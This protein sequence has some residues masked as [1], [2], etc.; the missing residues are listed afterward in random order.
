MSNKILITGA[1]G[2]IGFYLA[3]KL[4]KDNFS[5]YGID[6]LNDYYDVALKKDRL[7]I[8]SSQP[9][10]AFERIDLSDRDSLFAFIEKVKPSIVIN[11]AAQ[12]GV[13][14]SI[15][16]P[17]AYVESNLVGFAN[18]LEAC[19]TYPVKHL[20]YASSSSVYGANKKFLFPNRIM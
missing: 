15:T 18:L 20:I 7:K 8:L 4:I 6:N 11:L 9:N 5:V 19:R 2:F 10:F 16:N 1:A 12:A 3:Q 13:R 14:Y 17:Q